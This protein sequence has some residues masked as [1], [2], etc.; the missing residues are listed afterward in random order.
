MSHKLLGLCTDHS[1][2][3]DLLCLDS[4]C[5][6][7]DILWKTAVEFALESLHDLRPAHVPPLF[8]SCHALAFICLQQLRDD[9]ERICLALVIIGR[10]RTVLVSIEAPTDGFDAELFKH[11]LM[12]LL[13]GENDRILCEG[14]CTQQA[15][16]AGNE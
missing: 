11:I 5:D 16:H 7:R 13:C 8:F 1:D 4:P 12:I 9:R 2:G 10:V 6:R 3:L 14:R 15:D